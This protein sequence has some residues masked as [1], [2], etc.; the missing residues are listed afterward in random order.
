M[1][2]KS[3]NGVIHNQVIKNIK[4]IVFS[5]YEFISNEKVSKNYKTKV[6]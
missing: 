3:G 5:V 1:L 2:Q 6:Q 4:D